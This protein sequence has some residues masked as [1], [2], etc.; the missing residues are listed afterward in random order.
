[1]TGLS[2]VQNG[3]TVSGSARAAST[4][5]PL[6]FFEPNQSISGNASLVGDIEYRG[7]GT[8]KSSGTYFG[9]VDPASPAAGNTTDVTVP[10]PYLFRP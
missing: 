6:G 2:I 3:F 1:V 9:F 7:A 4:F 8:N 10:P 5:Y